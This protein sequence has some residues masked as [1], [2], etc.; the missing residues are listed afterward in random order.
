MPFVGNMTRMTKKTV[1]EM[2]ET[3]FDVLNIEYEDAFGEEIFDLPSRL[4]VSSSHSRGD[5]M[6]YQNQWSRIEGQIREFIEGKMTQKY[7]ESVKVV[8]F[9]VFFEGT[10]DPLRG[11]Y[12]DYEAETFEAKQIGS[13]RIAKNPNFPSGT[14]LQAYIKTNRSELRKVF[15]NPNYGG[16]RGLNNEWNLIV[17]PH[18][19]TI[20]DVREESKRGT[21]YFN[22]GG[23]GKFGALL[24]AQALS[25]HRNERVRAKETVPKWLEDRRQYQQVKSIDEHPDLTYERAMEYHNN[26]GR[27]GAETFEE[28]FITTDMS[29]SYIDVVVTDDAGSS[30]EGR[31]YGTMKENH[32]GAKKG[33]V[34]YDPSTGNVVYYHK[35]KEFVGDVENS[36]MNYNAETFEAEDDLTFKEWAD[37]EMMTHGGRE[38]FDDWL[39]DELESHGDNVSLQDW[40][41]HEL[42]SHYER[43][44]AEEG[45][46]D[47]IDNIL[48]VGKVKFIPVPTPE[49]EYDE[50][51]RKI[52][53]CFGCMRRKGFRINPSRGRKTASRVKKDIEKG[54]YDEGDW[55]E[56]TYWCPGT[57]IRF[58]REGE[59]EKTTPHEWA[60]WEK[61]PQL[62][63]KEERRRGRFRAEEYDHVATLRKFVAWL[64]KNNLEPSDVMGFTP[65]GQVLLKPI[66]QRANYKPDVMF[67][68]EDMNW[69]G[70]PKGQLA[71]A[72]RNARIKAKEPKKP[73][74]IEKL[75]AETSG[76]WEIGEQLEEAQMNAE[77]ERS[78]LVKS[79]PH[80]I[81]KEQH[82]EII[83]LLDEHDPNANIFYVRYGDT[84][85]IIT[86]HGPLNPSFLPTFSAESDQFPS[87]HYGDHD[88]DAQEKYQ[89]FLDEWDGDDDPPSFEEWEKQLDEYDR[90]LQEYQDSAEYAEE[91][92]REQLEEA[93]MNAEGGGRFDQEGGKMV[94][95]Y[96]QTIV[97]YTWRTDPDDANV[98]EWRVQ[99]E[100]E[101]KIKD[102]MHIGDSSYGTFYAYDN[103]THESI[104]V[105]YSWDK[106]IEEDDEE[107]IKSWAETDES[108]QAEGKKRKR[109]SVC[110]I[111]PFR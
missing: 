47:V 91:L 81:T 83:K 87:M 43:Y 107:I 102:E 96:Y 13:I 10:K 9:T 42:D 62:K 57:A 34:S 24:V 95:I 3:S 79:Y 98:D 2:V 93:Q 48:G 38:S 1:S 73:L 70:D 75:D 40:G 68:A 28:S 106:T 100:V 29:P 99:D 61:T 5:F 27:Y 82:D 12:E 72:L 65:D 54:I 17:G 14:S 16:M 86:P 26:R 55:A 39:D 6:F 52:R 32:S 109:I 49:P 111:R 19:V 97:D 60:E 76:Q 7:G 69:G 67:S 104:Q 56:V 101:D 88:S 44:G 64:K 92:A 35:G 63:D 21:K 23:S 58:P 4:T 18:R 53:M 77:W 37:Q 94:S 51:G 74:K 90:K 22:I 41:H 66:T 80:T 89:E 50:E 85:R 84:M 71:T 15:G 110:I 45:I 36:D 59:G 108:L 20:Y 11:N 31:L 46:K 25:I 78:W 105:S 33:L 8:D 30:F 103:E